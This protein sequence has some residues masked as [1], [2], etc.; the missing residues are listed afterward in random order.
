VLPLLL[1]ACAP[2]DVTLSP[3]PVIIAHHGASSHAPEH[4]AAAYDLALAQG[5]HYLE[6][7]VQLTADG[8]LVAIHDETLDRTA[9]GPAEHCTGLVRE[10]TLAQRRQCDFGSW[11]NETWPE[12][13]DPAFAGLP[14]LT[15]D[16]IIERYGHRVGLY[17]EMKEPEASPGMEAVLVDLPRRHGLAANMFSVQTASCQKG[18]SWKH[19]T[20]EIRPGDLLRHVPDVALSEETS[21]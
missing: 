17:L 2:A 6:Q 13:A 16:E 10:R 4:T 7:D 18:R 20:R 15:L 3:P 19:V 11:F 8:V 12:R 5:A 21:Q 14:I 9:R 1:G